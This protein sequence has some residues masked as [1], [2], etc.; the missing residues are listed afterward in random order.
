MSSKKNDI[1]WM[2]RFSNY[3]LGLKQLKDAVKL[4]NKRELSLIEKQGL[5]QSFEF[6]HELAWKVLKDYLEYQGTT[7]IRGSRDAVKESYK[8]DLINEGAVW[9]EMIE[10]RNI[11]SHTYDKETAEKTVVSIVE[12]Y[13]KELVDLEKIMIGIIDEESD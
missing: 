12:K 8:I 7:N 11:T 3:E 13:Y 2:Q 6:T 5:I 10:T 4:F 1:R 9:I